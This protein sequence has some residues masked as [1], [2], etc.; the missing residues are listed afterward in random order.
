MECEDETFMQRTNQLLVI[1][2]I[3]SRYYENEQQLNS[4]LEYD[5]KSS[6]IK[7]TL[8]T[9]HWDIDDSR[10]DSAVIRQRLD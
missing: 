5:R 2:I 6:N 8:A 1:T 9:M 7:S 10:T 3:T 4:L